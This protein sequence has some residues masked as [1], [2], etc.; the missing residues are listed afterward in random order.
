MWCPERVTVNNRCAGEICV[1]RVGDFCGKR[2]EMK[3]NL[4]ILN[5]EEKATMRKLRKGN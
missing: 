1:Y 2:L 5:K 3:K 4:G